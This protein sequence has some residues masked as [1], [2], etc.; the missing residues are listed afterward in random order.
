VKTVVDPF[1]IFAPPILTLIG[2]GLGYLQCRM[3][4]RGKPLSSIQRKML[5]F[6]V[7]DSGYGLRN[8]ASRP[9]GG[10]ISLGKRLD[11]R[12][13]SMGRLVGGDSLGETSTQCGFTTN[14]Y[15]T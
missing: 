14:R 10:T 7:L 6:C 11:R 15:S 3:I 9:P 1:A 2:I 12:D 8:H 4:Q 13:G 5:F